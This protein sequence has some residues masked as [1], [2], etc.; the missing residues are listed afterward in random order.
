M[1]K[2]EVLY[3]HRTLFKKNKKIQRIWINSLLKEKMGVS[4]LSKSQ[5]I[6]SDSPAISQWLFM[7]IVSLLGIYF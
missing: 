4:I 5:C 3:H 2:T 6:P 1:S 7:K